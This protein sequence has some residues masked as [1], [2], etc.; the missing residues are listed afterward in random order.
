MP[1]ERDVWNTTFYH[2]VIRK[3]IGEALSADYDLSKPLPDRVRTLLE[4]LDE[5]TV[6]GVP[7]SSVPLLPPNIR[8]IS[9]P[10]KVIATDNL[11]IYINGGCTL[12]EGN[13]SANDGTDPAAQTERGFLHLAPVW[14]ATLFARLWWLR[15]A[16]HMSQRMIAPLDPTDYSVCREAQ[17]T[18]TKVL[19]VGD[20]SRRK[21]KP[22]RAV[23]ALLSDHGDCRQSWKRS[24]QTTAGQ[25]P[26]RI[27][28]IA[29]SVMGH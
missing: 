15:A 13:R 19:E 8:L 29:A 10:A 11:M 6:Q 25:A 23:V 5:P 17:S 9:H 16:T 2:R 3:K 12:Y 28:T 20:L 4:K 22:D 18:S 7:G 21:S 24:P 27:P 1:D 26:R 14:T